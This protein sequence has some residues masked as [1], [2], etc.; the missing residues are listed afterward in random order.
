MVIKTQLKSLKC[1][2]EVKDRDFSLT[3]HCVILGETQCEILAREERKHV[4]FQSEN[5]GVFAQ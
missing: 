5:H 3:S 2:F 1:Y 4:L